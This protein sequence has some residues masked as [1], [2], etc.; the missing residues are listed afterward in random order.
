MKMN[1]KTLL[2]LISIL[3][4]ACTAI[5]TPTPTRGPAGDLGIGTIFG[6]VTDTGSGAPIAGATVTCEHSSYVSKED[7]RCNRST[8]TDQNGNFQFENIFFHDTDTITLTVSAS[9]Y[10]ATTFRQGF[11][12]QPLFEANV[13]LNP[14]D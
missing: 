3:L 6:L 4:L 1:I 5:G 14:T 13:Q 7:L 8:V 2:I 11:F 9:G 10:N 12:T